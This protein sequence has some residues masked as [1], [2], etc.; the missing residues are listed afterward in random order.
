MSLV[1]WVRTN[2][3]FLKTLQQLQILWFNKCSEELSFKEQEC[4][5]LRVETLTEEGAQVSH[6][7]GCHP[8]I[9]D[10]GKV[11]NG[12][13]NC[14]MRSNGGWGAFIH[15]YR[16]AGQTEF[17]G[18]ILTPAQSPFPFPSWK[19]CLATQNWRDAE[20][21]AFPNV[22]KPV[23]G[24]C[25]SLLCVIRVSY[26]LPC[27]TTCKNCSLVRLKAGNLSLIPSRAL[28]K[29]R[30]LKN[31]SQQYNEWERLDH[32]SHTPSPFLNQ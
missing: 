9:M 14:L 25:H 2:F 29:K 12:I 19:T 20:S 13:R 5:W 32:S 27:N 23:S 8:H 21:W 4:V 31:T 22:T 24:S 18:V 3:F 26:T 1:P 15:S 28:A 10:G 17:V 6:W 11:H 7:A 30:N 16:N